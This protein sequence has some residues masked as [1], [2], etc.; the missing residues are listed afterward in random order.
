MASVGNPKP[1]DENKGIESALRSQLQTAYDKVN[2]ELE[3]IMGPVLKKC[4]DDNSN[5]AV[6][7]SE[8]YEKV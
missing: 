7:I 3:R 1:T 4:V 2:A 5:D 6:K 8:C